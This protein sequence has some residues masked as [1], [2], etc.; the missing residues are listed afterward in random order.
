MSHV[1]SVSQAFAIL[2]LIG[3]CGPLTLSEVANA[4]EFSPSTCLTILRTLIDEGILERETKGKRYRLTPAWAASSPFTGDPIQRAIDQ[5][6]PTM[7]I[8]SEQF[9]ATVGVWQLTA[10]RRLRLVAHLESNAPMRIQM[11]PG[12]RQ[13]LGGGVMG[14]ILSAVQGV[15]DLELARRFSETRWERPIT[16]E[17]YTNDVK[18]AR[19]RGFAIDDGIL[20]AGICSVGCALTGQFQGFFISISIFAG[21]R[22]E[23]ELVRIGNHLSNRCHDLAPQTS[24]T[25]AKV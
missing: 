13:P 7:I 24:S 11:A 5:L 2:R 16:L 8:L 15:D 1:R 18:L 21:S 25:L 3:K 9:Q 23:E 14:R 22:N 20:H 4:R 6:R 12:Q 19:R 17:E 10:G